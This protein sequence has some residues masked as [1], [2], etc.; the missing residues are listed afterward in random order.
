ME[1]GNE[2]DESI[3]EVDEGDEVRLVT[4]D[5]GEYTINVESLI[6]SSNYARIESET[7]KTFM[8][9]EDGDG[10]VSTFQPSYVTYF[11][12]MGEA[13]LGSED[14]LEHFSEIFD[15]SERRKALVDGGDT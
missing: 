8:Y 7:G 11:E 4:R 10:G 6:K 14:A 3:Y 13:L 1:N 5:N 9:R 15:D 2:F 12:V